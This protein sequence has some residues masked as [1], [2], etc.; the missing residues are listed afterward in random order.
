MPPAAA[1][2]GK[3]VRWSFHGRIRDVERFGMPIEGS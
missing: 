3:E 1:K 2:E